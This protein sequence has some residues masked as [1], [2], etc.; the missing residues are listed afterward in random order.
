M[1]LSNRSLPKP[2]NWQD[3]EHHAWLLFR[4]ELQDHATEKNGRQGQ[5]QHGVDVYGRRNRTHWVGVQ[6]KQKMDEAVTETELRDEVEKA[7]LFSPK[8][9]EYI[10]VTTARRDAA[11]QKAAREITDELAGTDHGFSVSVWGWDQFQEHASLHSDVWEQIDPTYDPFSKR[12]LEQIAVK[13]D[14]VKDLVTS[15]LPDAQ[16]D[17]R[18]PSFDAQAENES[19]PRHTKITI[20]VE[21]IENGNLEIGRTGLADLKEADWG[22]ATSSEKYRILIGLASAALK[23]GDDSEAHSL[24]ERAYDICPDHRSSKRNLATSKLLQGEYDQARKLAGEA[25]HARP[26]DDIAAAVLVQARSFFPADDLLAGLSENVQ[27]KSAVKAALCQAYRNRD[28]ATWLTMAV[29]AYQ[30]DQSDDQIRL[31]WAEAVLELEIQNNAK[32]AQGGISE[33]P[34]FQ[35]LNSA[36]EELYQAC[37]SRRSRFSLATIH[38]A[39]LALRLVDRNDE[40]KQVLEMGLALCSGEPSISLQ[41]A[42]IA[43]EDRDFG[44][45]LELLDEDSEHPEVISLRTEATAHILSPSDALEAIDRS[46]ATNWSEEHRLMLLSSELTSLSK[47]GDWNTAIKKCRQGLVENPDSLRFKIVLARVLRISGDVEAANS[48]LD[49][50]VAGLPSDAT[51]AERVEIAT[52]YRQL[53]NHDQIVVLLEDQVSTQHDSEALRLLLSALISGQ[54]HR[55]ALNLFNVF[56]PELSSDEWYLR[57]RSILAINSGAADIENHLNAYLRVEPNDLEMQISR[58]GLWQ[59]QG[60]ESE[61]GRKL[62]TFEKKIPE[63]NPLER[64]RLCHL[65]VQYGNRKWGVDTAYQELILNWDDPAIHLA[66]QGLI[67]MYDDL[68]DAIPKAAEIQ[69]NCVF[70]TRSSDGVRRA[71]I[72]GTNAHNFEAERHA[73]T[74]EFAK[75]CIGKT[76]GEKFV[77]ATQYESIEFEVLWIKPRVLDLLHKSLEEFNKRFPTNS[78]M[79]RM[80][81]DFQADNPLVDMERITK[82]AHDRDQSVLDNYAANALPFCFVAEALG[83]DVVDGWAG[84]PGVGIQPRVCIGSRDERNNAIKEIQSNAERGCVLDP[85]TAALASDFHLW[86]TISKVCGP[87]HVTQ[88]TLEVFAKREIEAKNNIDRRSGITS[89]QDGR[90]TMIEIT[91]EQNQIDFEVKKRQREDVLAHCKIATSVPRADLEGQDLEIS[92]VLGSSAR[93]S[94][95]AAE[96]NGFL[97]LS[98]DQGLRQWASAALEVGSSWLQPV[99]LLAKDRGFVSIEDYTKFIVD[100]LNRDFTYVSMDSQTL[101]TQAKADGF[102]GQSTAKRMLEVVGGKNADLETNIGV[103]AL[104]LDLVFRETKQEHLRNRYASLVLEAFCAPRRGKTIEVI[105]LLTAQVSIRVFNLIEHA[106][107]WL[108]GREL[109]TPNFDQQVEEAKKSQLQRPVSLPHAIRFRVTEKIRLLGSCIPN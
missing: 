52:E 70:E 65:A 15:A 11:I 22:S 42:I 106:F 68:E 102:S 81:F 3:F 93:D 33:F 43:H 64:M 57:A 13:I 55:R 95:L 73:P 4:A 86:E 16:N 90:F 96:G 83:K 34:S 39:G 66:Y 105:K 89:W 76:V 79:Q 69:E 10:L 46:D 40:A 28:D 49:E 53:G 50:I 9:K 99:L 48:Q 80:T 23:F 47:M 98:E 2:E 38:N 71:R 19:S 94:V 77:I 25:V 92:E 18:P 14:E 100:C 97:L 67:L 75:A 101:L 1:S 35:D 30:S 103:A 45:I 58:L 20:F 87:V 54:K 7:K 21:M 61:I 109:G 62:R 63:G 107:W 37:V 91:P 17:L 60:R 51:M 44:R 72:E 59:L 104:F 12:G 74:S 6:C 108:V 56:P 82:A 84:L 88:T 31:N 78:G 85:I 27:G 36:A 24:I 32:S 5:A 26:D 41:L 29:E 8:I